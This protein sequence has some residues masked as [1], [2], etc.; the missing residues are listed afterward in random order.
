M[1]RALAAGCWL[2]LLLVGA[3]CKTAPDGAALLPADGAPAAPAVEVDTAVDAMAKPP[4]RGEPIDAGAPPTVAGG[5]AIADGPVGADVPAGADAATG[6][7]AAP[8]ADVAAVADGA[9][10][11]DA[12]H[13]DATSPPGADC[14][15]LPPPTADYS[16]GVGTMSAVIDGVPRQF[17]DVTVIRTRGGNFNFTATPL[18]VENSS[19]SF[20]VNNTGPGRFICGKNPNGEFGS[21][22]Y[23]IGDFGDQWGTGVIE[24]PCVISFTSVA[25]NLCERWEGSFSGTL[26]ESKGARPDVV[27]TEGRFSVVRVRF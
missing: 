21:M 8:A 26:A 23:S 17:R 5:D 16:F 15:H 25:T 12:P 7:D 9:G 22:N 20:G 14:S 18:P 27:I 13:V 3:G 1:L 24:R 11:G 10:T 2:G 6:A 4:G 19:F